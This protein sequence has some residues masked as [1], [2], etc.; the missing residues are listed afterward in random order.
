MIIN[1]IIKMENFILEPPLYLASDHIFSLDFHP[2]NDIL[3][4]SLI[5]GQI[6]M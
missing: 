6:N 3:S 2:Q 4:C 5:T 1:F